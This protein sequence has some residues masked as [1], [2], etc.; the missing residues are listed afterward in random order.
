MTL[1]VLKYPAYLTYPSSKQIQTFNNRRYTMRDIG[2]LE[3]RIQNLELYTSLSIAELATLNK[4]DR[5]VRDSVGLS[6]PKNGVFVDSFS[7]K[8]GSLITAPDFNA[9]ID[10]VG[11]QLRGSYNIA[12]TPIFS[13]NST[14]NYNVEIDGPLLMLASSN[15]TFISQNKSSTTLNINPF[16]VVNYLGSVKLDPPSDVWK[17]VTRL[18]SQNIDLSGG[19]AAR[20][21]WSSIQSTSWGSWQ[22]TC[23]GV[24]TQ[25]IDNAVQVSAKRLS[26][27]QIAVTTTQ[28]YLETTTTN[29][30]R[31]GILSQIV[32]QQLTKSLGDRVVDV[33]VVQFMRSI[34]ILTVGTGFKPSTTL[35]TFFDNTNVD[36]YVY[37]ANVI[38]FV[39]NSLQYRTTISDPEDVGFYDV[40]T[41]SLMGSGVVVLTADNHAFFTNIIPRSA[42]GSWSTATSGI[43]VVGAS[44][45]A[46]NITATLDHYSGKA[47]SA[48]SSTIVLDY[49]AGGAS[50]TSDYVGQTIRIIGGT[51]SGTSAV[52]SGYVPSTRTVSITGTW[53]TTPDATSTYSIGTLTTSI[54]GATAGIFSAPTDT[55]RTG[56]KLFRLIDSS[57]GSVESSTTNGDASFFSQGLIQTKQETSV[58]VFV[59]GVVRSD[60]TESRSTSSSTIRTSSSTRIRYVDPLAET[61]L[62]NSDQYPQGLMLSS[63]RVCFK[64]KDVSAPVQLQIRPAVNGIP[65]SSTIYPYADTSLTPDKVNTC[66]IPNIEDSTK[67]TEFKF[68]VPVFLLPG[69]HSIVLLSNSIGYETFVAEKDQKNLASSAKINKQPYTGSFFESQNGS[70]WTP[71]QNIDMMFSL[72]KKVYSNNYGYAYFETDMS[73]KTANAVYDLMHVMSTDVVLS[74]T[75]VDYNFISQQDGT[76]ATHTFLPFISNNDYKMV[77]GFGRRVLSTTTGNTTFILRASLQSNN[78]DIS[79]MIDITRFNL[80]TIENKINNLG[81]SNSDIV[82]ANVGQNMQDGIYSL[83]LSGGGGSGAAASANVVGGKLSRAWITSTGTGYVTSPTINL[84]ASLCTSV[85]GGSPYS[86]GITVGASSNGASIIING[87]D[88]KEGGN[89]KVRYLTRKVQLA[90]GFTSGDLRV[91]LLAYKPAL[92]NIYVYGKYL[93]PGDSEPFEDKTWNLLTQI[94]YNNFVSSDEKDFRELTFAPGTAGVVTN[95]I[96]YTNSAGTQTFTDFAT[97]AVKV[98]MTGDSTVD[99][100]KI[101]DLRIIALPDGL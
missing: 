39:N 69:E 95:Q 94:N 71:N 14:A 58:S 77:D 78:P 85:S 83:S 8:G 76:G 24:N 100:P 33:T 40:A 15:T 34:N 45:K 4:N 61:F 1:Y 66:T 52:I 65:S 3:K 67:Y 92:S 22:T 86:G 74:N 23:T 99:V 35:Y 73:S 28:D 26:R 25:A 53:T 84:F 98:V 81:L 5:T 57:T 59:P 16:N 79:P 41:G 42:Y 72:Q 90:P 55:F 37:R 62:I 29:E 7:D 68:D 96:T 48:T 18:E 17:S 87:E 89:A 54:E 10:I 101:K 12:S 6:R 44:S 49:H 63:V 21:A 82:V 36:K 27:R 20:D 32:P 30:T 70:T 9:A 19:D 38:K 2:G 51:G 80:L 88:K 50:N 13:N 47:I 56:E 97:F 46:T 11:K 60:V 93:S 64:T 91:Y 75:S 43:C 31:S